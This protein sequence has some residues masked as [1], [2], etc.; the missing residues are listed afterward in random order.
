MSTDEITEGVKKSVIK[1]LVD[2][3]CLDSFSRAGEIQLQ[4]KTLN[5]KEEYWDGISSDF[6]INIIEAYF[7]KQF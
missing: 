1:M 5:K 6:G 2:G 7:K 3:P 4:T